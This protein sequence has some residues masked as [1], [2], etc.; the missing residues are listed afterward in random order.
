MR[1]RERVKH[2]ASVGL[3][4]APADEASYVIVLARRRSSPAFV[5][6]PLRAF[7]A[8]THAVEEVDGAER[9]APMVRRLAGVD[10]G[11]SHFV[12]LWDIDQRNEPNAGARSRSGQSR[13]LLPRAGKHMQAA[14]YLWS[15]D[16]RPTPSCCPSWSSRHTLG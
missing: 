13:V 10:V 8:R 6:G 1:G 7:A 16:E 14:R 15:G 9:K 5:S 2:A 11:K 3:R 4:A 12:A